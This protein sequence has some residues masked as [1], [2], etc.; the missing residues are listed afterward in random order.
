MLPDGEVKNK[1]D[2]SVYRYLGVLEG[3]DIQNREMKEK[4]IT[5]YFRQVKALARSKLYA[6]SLLK[7]I[8]A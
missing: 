2:R 4:I 1:V 8:N 7:G 6:G 3:A 5:E